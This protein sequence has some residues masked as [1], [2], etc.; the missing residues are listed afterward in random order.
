MSHYIVSQEVASNVILNIKKMQ[1]N[2]QDGAHTIYVYTAEVKEVS[3]VEI[4]LDFSEGFN[5]KV[6]NSSDLVATSVVPPMSTDTI[7][8]LR[9]YDETWANPCKIKM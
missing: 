1:T 8:V 2:A 3:E 6:E 4:T 5:V 9:A 7:C